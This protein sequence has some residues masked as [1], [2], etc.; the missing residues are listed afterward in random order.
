MDV[1][2][3]PA[4]ID[5]CFSFA[6]AIAKEAG[7]TVREAFYLEKNVETKACATDLVTQTD[8]DV[9][10]LLFSAIR[11][12]FPTHSFIGE[13]SVAAGDISPFTDRPTWIIDPVDG[14]TNF[15]HRFPY[16]AVCIGFTY[17]KITQFG[18]VYNAI[19]DELFVAKRGSG[20]FLNGKSIRV[21]HEHDLCK[22]LVLTEC[23]SSRD[24]KIVEMLFENMKSVLTTPVHT[25]HSLGSAALNIC[26]VAKGGGEVYYEFG[27]HCW[28]FCAAGVILEE[29][30]GVVMNCDGSPFNLMSRQIIAANNS[31]IGLDLSKRIIHQISLPHDCQ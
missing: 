12:K 15:V 29:A 21:S 24:S 28:D 2:L 31:Q 26:M 22:S 19:L 1:V 20:A 18:V 10:K 7:K 9:E 4:E 5:E 16:V 11:S 8:Q 14:T 17:Q 30:G 23:G 13:E 6:S 3:T 27:C 25:I